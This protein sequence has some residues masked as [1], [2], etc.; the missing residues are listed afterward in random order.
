[1][2]YVVGVSSEAAGAV[3]SSSSMK[4]RPSKVLVIKK[5]EIMRPSQEISPIT[6]PKNDDYGVYLSSKDLVLATGI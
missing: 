1:M 6:S 3:Q 2:S 4:R 5:D